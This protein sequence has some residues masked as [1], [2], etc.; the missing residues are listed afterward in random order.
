MSRED[1]LNAVKLPPLNIMRG[2]LLTILSASAS[3][4]SRLLNRHQQELSINLGQLVKQGGGLV[5]KSSGVDQNCMSERNDSSTGE[6][7]T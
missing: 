3:K 1:I 7:Q 2:Q 6:A 4:T 5:E